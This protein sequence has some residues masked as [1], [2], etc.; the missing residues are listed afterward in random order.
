MLP[1]AFVWENAEILDFIETVEVYELNKYEY[2]RSV[3][4][5]DLCPRSLIFIHSNICCKAARPIEATFHV[6]LLWVVRM[7]ICSNGPGRMT[8]LAAK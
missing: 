7:K 3:S 1:N 4:L 8:K 6:V 2:Q 5:F